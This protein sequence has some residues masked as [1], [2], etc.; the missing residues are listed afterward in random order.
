LSILL[1]EIMCYNRESRYQLGKPEDISARLS[2]YQK[3][4][5]WESPPRGVKGRGLTGLAQSIFL[6]YVFPSLLALS[7]STICPG[8]QLTKNTRAYFSIAV[9]A[10][11]RPLASLEMSL[12]N[13]LGS[14]STF[15]VQHCKRMVERVQEFEQMYPEECG[16]GCVGTLYFFYVVSVSLV[17]LL[18][19]EPDSHDPFVQSCRHFHLVSKN[20]GVGRALL[21]G[22]QAMALE[23]NAHLPEQSLSYFAEAS[24]KNEHFKD[25]PVSYV[26]PQNAP[27]GSAGDGGESEAE[28]QLGNLIEKW[29]AVS[30]Q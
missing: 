6:Q 17:A 9:I 11:F 27:G 25:V 24:L 20:Y 1:Y 22:M 15:C 8:V 30:I 19:K 18:D 4:M 29:S 2:L 7:I 3:L 26:I 21:R 13:G 10:L 23:M 14:P 12:P 16:K 5:G 28:V